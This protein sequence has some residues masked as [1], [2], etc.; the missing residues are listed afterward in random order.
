MIRHGELASGVVL[1]PRGAADGLT[2]YVVRPWSLPLRLLHITG[3]A[4]AGGGPAHVFDL[5]Q[6]LES[7]G[8]ESWVA[9]P[10][11]GLWAPRFAAAIGTSRIL[12]I[13]HRL[14]D[15][16]ALEGLCAAHRAA[17]FDLIHSHGMAAGLYG[18]I[19][20][21]R[22]GI[23]CVHSFHGVPRTLSF[24][25]L[26][27][28][29]AIEPGLAPWTRVAVAVSEGE[30]RVVEER[31][32]YYRERLAVVPNAITLPQESPTPRPTTPIPR[33]VT[34]TRA[35][36]QKNPG[37]LLNIARALRHAGQSVQIDA[38]GEGMPEVLW[39]GEAQAQGIRLHPPTLD[40]IGVLRQADCYLST[41]RWEGMPISL[42]EAFAYGAV[43]VASA[44]TG[45][46][47]VVED[48]R[49]G[50]LYPE[51]DGTAAAVAIQRLASDPQLR[52]DLTSQAW[53]HVQTHHARELMAER[54]LAC[55]RRALA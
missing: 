40:P 41:S 39:R 32:P 24:K 21:A 5:L 13:P 35:N 37:L 20:A 27:Y 34:F 33:V 18:R 11:R 4:D 43:V 2:P 29:W 45:N 46:T 16:W 7:L 51:G 9:C 49:T 3:R 44:V 23:P 6:G 22:T 38:Y 19:M 52:C 12:S 28:R 55:Y 14:F 47:D 30:R 50:L 26:A 17:P 48:G 53:R 42:L 8:V 31:Y 54:M 15:P 1:A 10:R 25:H 36:A